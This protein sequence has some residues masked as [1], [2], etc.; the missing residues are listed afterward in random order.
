MTRKI[1]RALRATPRS[2]DYVGSSLR[3]GMAPGW[4]T[5]LIIN[6]RQFVPALCQTQHGQQKI[7]TL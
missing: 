6:D 1:G 3:D 4:R 5:V 2:P 7:F